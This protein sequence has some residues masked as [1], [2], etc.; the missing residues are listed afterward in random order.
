MSSDLVAGLIHSLALAT[1]KVTQMDKFVQ[2]MHDTVI[3]LET[4]VNE[5]ETRVKELEDAT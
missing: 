4:K 5:L 3:T 2:S 1:E